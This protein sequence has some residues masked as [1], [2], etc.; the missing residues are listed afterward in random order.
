MYLA[1]TVQGN[2]SPDKHINVITGGTQT[3][4]EYEWL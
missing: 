3:V 1:M 2:L 4:D